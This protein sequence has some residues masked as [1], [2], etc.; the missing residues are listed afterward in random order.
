MTKRERQKV[1]I[2]RDVIAQVKA[3]RYIATSGTYISRLGIDED[4]KGDLQQIIK[5]K[6]TRRAP[7]DVCAL[8]SAFISTVRLYDKFQLNSKTN[9][10]GEIEYRAMRRKLE[11]FFSKIELGIIEASFEISE[12]HIPTRKSD[13][14]GNNYGAEIPKWLAVET[15]FTSDS[16]TYRDFLEQMDESDRLIWIMESIIELDGRPTL[17]GFK[18]EMLLDL[19][20]NRKHRDFRIRLIGG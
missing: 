1:A 7:C 4:T 16:A 10:D 18:T 19:A 11:Q 5:K 8:G 2:A 6:L 17:A 3:R 12:D 13:R 14:H 15:E 9:S 20:L